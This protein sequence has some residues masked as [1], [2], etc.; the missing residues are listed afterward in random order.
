[1]TG[2]GLR[3][4][5]SSGAL[6]EGK[7]AACEPPLSLPPVLRVASGSNL[8]C[9][10][11]NHLRVRGVLGPQ[12]ESKWKPRGDA[13]AKE[14][15]GDAPARLHL[16]FW[17]QTGLVRRGSL[18]E[19]EVSRVSNESLT[20][21][22]AVPTPY[23]SI[24]YLDL[25]RESLVQ[26]DRGSKYL[27]SVEFDSSQQE[28]PE[29][30]ERLFKVIIIG[31]PTVG[32]TSFVQRYVQDSFRRDYKGTVGVDF[33]LKILKWSDSET[34]KLQLWDIAGQER[35]TWMT[36]VYY[37]DAQGCIIMFDLTNRNSF[38]NTLKWKKDVDSKCTL[39][40]GSPIPCMLLA[41]KCDLPHRQVD[42]LE[43][44]KLYKDHSF[45]GWTE[46]SAKEGLMVTDSMRFLVDVMMKQKDDRDEDSN[47]SSLR[48]TPA[49]PEK[50][51][52][53]Y[54]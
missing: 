31:D 46:T 54:C 34:I 24:S 35:F 13:L 12:V 52:G 45:T 25:S 10:S 28:V 11:S 50:P 39:E 4:A 41:N 26:S 53:C 20:D 15:E 49:D 23:N 21:S 32:K 51:H 33:A 2:V 42:Q 7:A 1:M 38:L 17:P 8:A 30:T 43:I 14:P 44:E 16:V 3:R 37:K 48:L 27:Q 9:T 5:G 18:Q 47:Q 22:S 36:R 29:M 6:S 40:D 19:H